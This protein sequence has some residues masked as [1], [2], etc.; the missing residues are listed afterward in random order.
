[1]GVPEVSSHT[2]EAF[3]FMDEIVVRFC[4]HE[5]PHLN[6][7]KNIL[8]RL[9]QGGEEL[10]YGGRTAM[11]RDGEEIRLALFEAFGLSYLSTRRRRNYMH[12]RG[13]NERK[14]RTFG[15]SELPCVV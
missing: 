5:C 12:H 11:P 7:T 15:F 10:D 3:T 6:A 4:T 13:E 2:P 8:E 14:V 1:M 9:I